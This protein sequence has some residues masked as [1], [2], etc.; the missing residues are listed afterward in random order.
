MKPA[1]KFLAE[2]KAL[3]NSGKVTSAIDKMTD[4]LH[5][6]P[7]NKRITSHL[8]YLEDVRCY[9]I[10]FALKMRAKRS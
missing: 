6:Y 4:A 9:G 7:R 1:A 10:D 3:F 2:A 5:I 8:E